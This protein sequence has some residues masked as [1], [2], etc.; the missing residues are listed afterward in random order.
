[1]ITQIVYLPMVGD[2]TLIWRA[3]VVVSN[4]E[5]MSTHCHQFR[6]ESRFHAS[7]GLLGHSLKQGP[8]AV[9]RAT[10]RS[11]STGV[12]SRWSIIQHET[13]LRSIR[14]QTSAPDR[15]ISTTMG[16][17]L[18]QGYLY[19]DSRMGRTLQ[20][21]RLPRLEDTAMVA[22]AVARVTLTYGAH[23]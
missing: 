11:A 7:Q 5:G 21:S 3:R 16:H 13:G 6:I 18:P 17:G 23:R 19:V 15:M 9:N 22:N 14:A 2:G 1:L 4:D 12:V 10:E 8:N 20:K